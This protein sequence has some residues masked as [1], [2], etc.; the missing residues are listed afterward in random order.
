MSNP[1]DVG[2]SEPNTS[3]TA[4]PTLDCDYLS[5]KYGFDVCAPDPILFDTLRYL[6][7][8]LFLQLFQVKTVYHCYGVSHHLKNSKP[9]SVS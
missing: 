3:S 8:T 9:N 5:V 6:Y 2:G 4:T 7:R 1:I